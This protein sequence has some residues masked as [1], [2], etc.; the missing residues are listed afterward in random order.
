MVN[1]SFED[2]EIDGALYLLR[3]EQELS[4][5]LRVTKCVCLHINFYHNALKTIHTVHMKNDV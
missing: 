1:R 5:L 4:E 2:R 3:D